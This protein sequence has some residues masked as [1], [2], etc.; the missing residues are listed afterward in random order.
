MSL[1]FFIKGWFNELFLGTVETWSTYDTESFHALAPCKIAGAVTHMR[2]ILLEPNN[3]SIFCILS[4]EKLG[5]GVI[6]SV[7]A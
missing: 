5:K 4:I 6:K 3:M 2:C 7:R 1:N